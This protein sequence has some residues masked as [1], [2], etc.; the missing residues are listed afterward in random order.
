MPQIPICG[1]RARWRLFRARASSSY[2]AGSRSNRALAASSAW[3]PSPDYFYRNFYTGNQRWN[4]SSIDDPEINELS[5]SYFAGSRSNR[6]LAASSL[7]SGSS[8]E[9]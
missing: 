6:A 8:I 2:F 1:I 5:S 7:I 9:L 4:Y 3:L